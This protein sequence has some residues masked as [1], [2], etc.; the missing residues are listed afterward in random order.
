M[1]IKHSE[2][3]KILFKKIDDLFADEVGPVAMILCEEVLVEWAR[4]THKK[5][6][7]LGLRDIHT[8][9]DKLSVKIED[10]HSRKRFLAAVYEIETLK[11]SRQK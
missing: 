4:E 8:Y 6:Q 7:R 3:S 9:I 11:A 10:Q 1:K 2:F 5:Q